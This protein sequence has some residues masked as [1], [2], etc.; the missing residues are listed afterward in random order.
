MKNKIIFL[1]LASIIIV[2]GCS[3]PK[4]VS[5][6]TNIPEV[7]VSYSP[8]VT[9]IITP[10]I[11][12][13]ATTSPTPPA[14]AYSVYM[15]GATIDG[16]IP[17]C[18]NPPCTTETGKILANLFVNIKLDNLSPNYFN[19]WEEYGWKDSIISDVF[20]V[21][22]IIKGKISQKPNNGLITS[23]DITA[24]YFAASSK[25]SYQIQPSESNA[26]MIFV[27]RGTRYGFTIIDTTFPMAVSGVNDMGFFQS[28]WPTESDKL[29]GDESKKI[30]GPNPK[31]SEFTIYIPIRKDQQDNWH[32]IESVSGKGINFRD[33]E[34]Q[35]ILNT[36]TENDYSPKDGCFE[37]L[38]DS[39]WNYDNFNPE[40][41]PNW[42]TEWVV[43][44]E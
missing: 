38:I 22:V 32:Y 17:L 7:N 2:S 1:L 26:L 34:V 30:A 14:L 39:G 12:Q 21:P 41:N 16:Q 42:K 23:S 44:I 18:Q 20:K 29:S 25:P 33:V 8:K 9:V 40:P 28:L 13:E 4:T 11:T 6:D 37:G 5:N 24:D 43:P 10:E 36:P 19:R 27:N 3:S 15:C 35:R 31:V